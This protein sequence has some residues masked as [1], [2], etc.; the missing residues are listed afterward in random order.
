M[1]AKMS[2]IS[3]SDEII[4]RS[5]DAKQRSSTIANATI[6]IGKVGWWSAALTTIFAASYGIAAILLMVSNLSTATSSQS[7]GWTGIDAFLVTFQTIQ[8]LPVI[9]SLLLAP[10][11]TALMVSIHS[12]A[13]EDK[14]IWSRVGLRISIYE[15]GDV[16]FCPGFWWKPIGESDPAAFY[17]ERRFRRADPCQRLFG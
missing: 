13:A 15:P 9:P 8:M 11:F 10:T 2:Q 1:E 3:I 14:K 17:L 12:F 5:Q 4:I 6:T 7:Q 16:V